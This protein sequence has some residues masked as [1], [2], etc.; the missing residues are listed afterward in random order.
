MESSTTEN[1]RGV[2]L[3]ATQSRSGLALVLALLSVPGSTL[4][5]DLF[6]AGGF[7]IGLPLA[8][9]AIYLGIQARRAETSDGKALAAI[10]IAGAMILMMAVWTVVESL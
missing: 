5:W 8:V 10:V 6:D 7:V 1:R 3:S 2:D 9:A 4:A